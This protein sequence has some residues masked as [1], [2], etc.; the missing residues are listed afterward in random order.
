MLASGEVGPVIL[1]DTKAMASG[2]VSVKLLASVLTVAAL[3]GG[4]VGFAVAGPLAP[5]PVVGSTY[6]PQTREFTVVSSSVDFNETAVGIPHDTFTPST[7]VVHVGDTVVIHFYNVEDTTEAHTFTIGE[8]Y[9]IHMNVEAGQNQTATF[10]ASTAGVF[11]IVC[12][13]HQPTMSGQ[14]V[15]LA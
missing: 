14:F 15:V 7:I 1:T 10:V 6:A 2:T 8:P 3:A 12:A 9:H 13:Y 5:H 11:E 4:A